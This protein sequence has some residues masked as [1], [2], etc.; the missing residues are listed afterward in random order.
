MG[1][2]QVGNDLLILDWTGFS[3]RG[4]VKHGFVKKRLLHGQLTNFNLR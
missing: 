2:V 4:F 3:K 1:F